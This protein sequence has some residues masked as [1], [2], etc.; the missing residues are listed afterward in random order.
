MAIAPI[1]QKMTVMVTL[2][3][4]GFLGTRLGIT[5][6]GFNKYANPVVI[7]VFLPAT[8]LNAVIGTT[9]RVSGTVLAQ[10]LGVMVDLH[11]PCR[12]GGAA[13]S[14]A[15]RNQGRALV[16]HIVYE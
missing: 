16:S 12:D 2:M 15:D 10:Y 9:E 14:G 1:L 5:G 13:A 3:L 11:A 6:P 4:I 7:N 8:I